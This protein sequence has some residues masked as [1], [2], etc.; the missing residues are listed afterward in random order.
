MTKTNDQIANLDAELDALSSPTTADT[1]VVS[2]DYDAD[3][4]ATVTAADSDGLVWGVDVVPS[5]EIEM[6]ADGTTWLPFYGSAITVAA[7]FTVVHEIDLGNP[8]V[9]G[10]KLAYVALV[11]RAVRFRGT[12]LDPQTGALYAGA[13]DPT[14]TFTFTYTAS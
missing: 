5:I 8:V 1:Y 10:Q 3:V 14:Y 2:K 13:D 4:V 9:V 12:V 7:A 11:P 6:S